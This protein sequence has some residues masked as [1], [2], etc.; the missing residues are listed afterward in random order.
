VKPK[1]TLALFPSTGRTKETPGTRGQPDAIRLHYYCAIYDPLPTPL[2]YAIHHA[3]LVMAISHGRGCGLSRGTG[4]R[5]SRPGPTPTLSDQL[6]LRLCLR[7]LCILVVCEG[8]AN[9]SPAPVYRT[10]EG[11]SAHEGS[12]WQGEARWATL[13]MREYTG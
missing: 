10:H 2:L 12:S 6:P 7:A 4:P 1:Q 11:D 8:Q 13:A 5:V 3:V 9:H